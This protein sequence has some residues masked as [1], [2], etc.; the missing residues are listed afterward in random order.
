MSGRVEIKELTK[1]FARQGSLR[2]QG[3][4][5]TLLVLDNISLDIQSGEFITLLGASG[6]GKSTLLRI[7]AGLEVPTKGSVLL[8]GEKIADAN[9]RRGLVFQEHTLFA[10]LTVKGNIEFALKAVKRYKEK[11]SEIA[12][13]LELGGLSEFADNYPHQLSGGMRQRAALVRALAVSPE[14]LLLDEPLGAL[15][16]LTRMNLQDELIRLWRERG[17]TMIMVTHD[18]DEAIYLSQRI[19]IMSPRPGRISTV[20]S[21]SE[22]YPRNRASGDFTLLRTEI[23]KIL[24]FAHDVEE[25]Y[26][27]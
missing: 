19:V 10:W 12:N 13:W 5:D 1:I 14:V 25:E 17:N 6:C 7:I 24:N 16:S 22:N 9:P 2:Q 20:L 8:E 26:T 18:I 23:L 21:V 15:D 3:M 4:K 27:I 11:K